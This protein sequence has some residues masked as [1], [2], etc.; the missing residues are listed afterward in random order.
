MQ[1][2]LF[3]GAIID[4]IGRGETNKEE[5]VDRDAVIAASILGGVIAVLN[6]GELFQQMEQ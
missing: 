4:L 3:A 5:D 1:L 2:L 6:A